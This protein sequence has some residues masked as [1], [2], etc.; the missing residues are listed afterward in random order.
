MNAISQEARDIAQRVEQFVLNVVVPYEKDPRCGS[1]GPSDELGSELRAKAK[2]EGL[3]VPHIRDDGS[4]FSHAETALIL[5]KSGLSPLGP[6]ACH[7]MAPDEGNM[8]LLGKVGSEDVK[9][10]FLAPLV[11]GEARSAFFMTEPAEDGG[12][13]SDPSLMKTTC[14]RDG[15]HWVINGRKSFITGAEGARVGII[16]AK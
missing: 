14:R 9:R 15:N 8:Y 12:A 1:H 2:A 7:V 5:R 16:M 3:L 4:H 11:A 6:I 13:G 10:R